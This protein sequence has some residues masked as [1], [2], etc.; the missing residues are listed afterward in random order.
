MIDTFM[1][2]C[3]YITLSIGMRYCM[4]STEWVSNNWPIVGQQVV[5]QQL[6]ANNDKARRRRI[7]TKNQG[8]SYHI[9]YLIQFNRGSKQSATDEGRDPR[10][11]AI[12]LG[13]G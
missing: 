7:P 12:Q 2:D 5:G 13:L 3:R 10:L 6:V 4:G 8:V 11:G 9:Q 1:I